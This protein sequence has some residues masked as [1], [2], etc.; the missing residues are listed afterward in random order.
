M[1]EF[2]KFP[3]T[4]HL[5]DSSGGIT[6]DDK[7]LANDVAEVFFREAIVIEEKVDGANMDSRSLMMAQSA[8]RTGETMWMQKVIRSLPC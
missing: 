1:D 4:S 7:L 2:I 6:R 5:L 8:R 3:Q